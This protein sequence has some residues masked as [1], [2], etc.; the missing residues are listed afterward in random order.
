MLLLCGGK[1]L[2]HNFPTNQLVINIDKS[3][4]YYHPQRCSTKVLNDG[5]KGCY[6]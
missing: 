3:K 6:Q 5:H 1:R 4:C 2:P